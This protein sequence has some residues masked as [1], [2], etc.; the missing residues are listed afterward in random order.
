MSNN[1]DESF[2]KYKDYDFADAQP[3]SAFPH[4][5]KLQAEGGGKTRITI[6]VD[7][8]LLA[9]V[10]A[11]AEMQG[12]TCQGLINQAIR[13]YVQGQQLVDLVR[14]EIRD[15]LAMELSKSQSKQVENNVAD[16]SA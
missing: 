2:D 14:K 1:F 15:T 7:N 16:P 5:Q 8:A 13:Q 12:D 11:Y 9:V 4:L 3:A 10:K 6:K